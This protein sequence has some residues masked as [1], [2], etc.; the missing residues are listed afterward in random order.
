MRGRR[1]PRNATKAEWP[2]GDLEGFIAWNG[3]RVD[4]SDYRRLCTTDPTNY[5][6]IAQLAKKYFPSSFE[7]WHGL[8]PEEVLA[9]CSPMPLSDVEER[10]VLVPI[11]PGYAMSLFDRRSAETDLFGG[12]SDIFM[13]WDNVY[14]KKKSHHL[15]LRSPARIL[16]YESGNVQAITANSRLLSV[17]TGTAK[18][19]YGKRR[20]YGTLE[21]SDIFKMCDGNVDREL[22]ALT[23]SHTFGF[24]Y[25]ISLDLLRRIE[26][27]KAVPLQS[28]RLIPYDEFLTIMRIGYDGCEE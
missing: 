20:R 28:P 9:R 12:K 17:E 21:W 6:E 3:I 24:R 7:A 19:L 27:R 11:R 23:F 8:P 5:D 4:R 14:F 2:I 18:S 25:P 22:M 16:W 1:S 13:R 15:V 26:G 10:C